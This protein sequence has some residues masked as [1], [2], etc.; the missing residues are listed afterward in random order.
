M[1]KIELFINNQLVDLDANT[2]ILFNYKQTDLTNPTVVKNSFSKT[3]ELPSTDR[4]NDVFGH[5][6]NLDRIQGSNFNPSKRVDFQLFMDGE[7]IETGYCKLTN[8]KKVLGNYT[9]SLTL[10]GGLG[11]FFYNLMYNQ[12]TDGKKTLAS[13]DYGYDL[14]FNINIDS[15]YE[16]WT[17]LTQGVLDSMWGVINFAPAYNGYPKIL[18]SD[19][20]VINT[21][22][23]SGRLRKWNGSAWDEITGFPTNDGEFGLLNGYAIAELPSSMTEWETRDLRS[24]LQTPVISMKSIIE[25]CCNPENNGGYTVELDEDFFNTWNPYYINAWVTLPSLTNLEINEKET[26]TTWTGTIGAS[27]TIGT[28]G[29]RFAINTNVTFEPN[30]S[31]TTKVRLLIQ[32]NGNL[33]GGNSDQNPNVLYTS[34]RMQG[35]ANLQ[36]YGGY[37]VQLVGLD[38]SGNEVAGSN[39]EWCTSPMPDG[40]YCQF[41]E[42]TMGFSQT[43]FKY[44]DSSNLKGQFEKDGQYYKFNREI[45]LTLK[46]GSNSIN[47]LAI[48][49][50]HGFR[51][52]QNYNGV[53]QLFS[54]QTLGVDRWNRFVF[55]CM[56]Q[57]ITNAN[58]GNT[59]SGGATIGER[60]SI[61][62]GV[63]AYGA[64]R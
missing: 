49:V 55:K 53:G 38:S 24:Y 59:I 32:N 9:Y 51:S 34:A 15:V 42:V 29:K 7:L 30:T 63:S 28:V 40:T 1:R 11:D 43:D 16:A 45:N 39:I 48:K 13:L 56:P 17:Y 33:A 31:F 2:N 52:S 3:V 18:D 4:N 54:Q 8:I 37:A 36:M 20:V 6:W 44:G 14:D 60:T 22:G 58:G 25:A 47:Q 57:S 27:Q 64:A 12:N 10:F 35:G 46:S 23:F 41:N 62:S 26:T 5:I 19:K 21:N 61:Y 50:L